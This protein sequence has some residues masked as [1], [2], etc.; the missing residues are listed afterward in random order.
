MIV[1]VEYQNMDDYPYTKSKCCYIK[2]EEII[3]ITVP[4]NAEIDRDSIHGWVEI[5]LENGKI[6]KNVRNIEYPIS[7]TPIGSEVALRFDEEKER[8][9]YITESYRLTSR[10]TIALDKMNET[11]EKVLDKLS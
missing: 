7:T 11:L 8:G 10:L 6:I 2:E 5:E 4:T 1:L 9:M 3:N